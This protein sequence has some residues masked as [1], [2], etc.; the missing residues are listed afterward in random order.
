LIYGNVLATKAL[1]HK[2]RVQ[3]SSLR[4]QLEQW[5]DGVMEKWV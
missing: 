1:R 2:E 5:N 3:V 4:S